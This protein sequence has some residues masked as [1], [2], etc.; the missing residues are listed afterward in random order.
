[1]EK[2]CRTFGGQIRQ[3]DLIDKLIENLGEHFC[4]KIVWN[5]WVDKF[6]AILVEK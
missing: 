5:N 4:E 1:V 3:T 6:V 2:L